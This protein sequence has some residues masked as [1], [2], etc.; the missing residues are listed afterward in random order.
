MD[1]PEN[2]IV[3]RYERVTYHQLG[4]IEAHGKR[5]GDDLDHIDL[6]RTE[7]NEFLVGNE[8]LRDIANEHVAR[9]QKDNAARK[10]AGLRRSR[11]KAQARKLEEAIESA[12]DDPHALAE[13]IG[14]PWDNKNVKPFTE[15][16][17]SVSH[18]WFLDD[19]GA[20][21]PAKI[22]AFRSFVTGYLEQEFGGEV[23]YARFD[24]DEK[25]PHISFVVAPEHEN[26]KTKRRELSHRQHRLFG[27]EEVQAL[28]DDEE[29]DP[30]LTRQ[31]YEILQDRIAVYAQSQGLDIARGER[32]ANAERTQRSAGETV[33]KRKNV[34]P[35][36]GREIAA[37]MAG[38]AAEDRKLAESERAAA[39]KD[40]TDAAD[41][42]DEAAQSL[43]RARKAI[44]D[45]EAEHEVIQTERRALAAREESLRIGAQAI[46]AEELVYSPPSQDQAEGLVW[47]RN[48]PKSPDRREWLKEK[49]KPARDWLVG[50]A[51]TI[52][53]FQEQRDAVAA[54]QQA[55]AKDIVDAEVR[56]GRQAPKTMLDLVALGEPAGVEIGAIPGAWALPKEMTADQIDKRLRGMTNTDL[57][58]AYAPTRDAGDFSEHDEVQVRYRA[59]LHHLTK[60]AAKRGLDVELRE[61]HPD[62]GTDAARARLH[63]DAPPL[64]I[65]VVRRDLAQQ[66]LISD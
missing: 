20:E 45:A 31:S 24:R 10:A 6:S 1:K 14:W 44:K 23:I 59:G 40:R 9:M 51:R 36:R 56:T 29:P 61:H 28:F 52:F 3:N 17:I 32:R 43:T 19:Q 34:S 58:D 41:E 55:R 25:T 53:G 2:L 18:A 57:C 38:E 15:G 62:K 27:M 35:A 5:L 42:R 50:F 33:I 13:V 26:R 64:A 60:E 54:D 21:D 47:G 65:H 66:R 49:T 4:A 48:R 63:M 16:L 7:L 37:A 39:E 46:I 22:T 12:G 30:K 8:H 11:H